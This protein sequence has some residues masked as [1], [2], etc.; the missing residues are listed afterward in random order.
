VEAGGFGGTIQGMILLLAWEDQ[1]YPMRTVTQGVRSP[2]VVIIIIFV[3]LY[4]LFESVCW[5]CNWSLR[6]RLDTYTNE[7]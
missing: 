4:V 2:G 1:G 5:F 6:F 7:K 3:L